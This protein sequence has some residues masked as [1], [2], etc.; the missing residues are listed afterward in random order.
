[1]INSVTPKCYRFLARYNSLQK[2]LSLRG[3]I[4]LL[5]PEIGAPA[6]VAQFI[7]QFDSPPRHLTGLCQARSN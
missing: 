4:Y 7:V 3:L 6:S 2:T 5:K 1:M